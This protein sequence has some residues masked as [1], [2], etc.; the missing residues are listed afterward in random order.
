MASDVSLFNSDGMGFVRRH[1]G[2]SFNPWST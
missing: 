1:D 2:K